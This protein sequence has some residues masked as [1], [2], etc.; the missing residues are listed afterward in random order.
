MMEACAISVRWP[1]PPSL[2]LVYP[3]ILFLTLFE[4]SLQAAKDGLRTETFPSQPGDTLIVRNDYGRVRVRTWDKKV[5][6][7]QIR[8]IAADD[9]HLNNVIVVSQ[10]SAHRIYLH[11]Y[12]YDYEAESVYI[13]L[14]VP[15]Y[16]NVFISGANPAVELY[17]LGG[18]ARVNTLTGLITAQDLHSSASLLTDTGDISYR[19]HTQPT[20]D[21]RLEAMRGNIHCQLT[22]KLNL[23]GWTRAGG[24]LS[25]NQ[26]IELKQGFLEKQM[27][28]GGPL[29]YASSLHGDVSIRL[30]P[31]GK[32]RAAPERAFTPS[33]VS[34]SR[35]QLLSSQ[36]EAPPAGKTPFNANPTPAWESRKE[37][38]RRE[39]HPSA[40]AVDPG[41]HLRVN[42]DWIYLNVSVRDRYSN[43]S[44]PG[45][46]KDDFLVYEDGVPQNV[47]KF[48]PTEA[49]FNLL[50]LL[51]V[52]GSTRNFLNLIKEASIEFTRQIKPNDRI[53]VAAFN[54]HVW[55]IQTFSNDRRTVGQAISRIRSGGGTAFYDAL[56]TC[57][58]DYMDGIEGRKAIVVFTDGVDNQ[59][60]GDYSHGSVITFPALYR[61]IQEIDS[62]IY[63]IFVNSEK[64]VRQIGPRGTGPTTMGG[65]LKD[66][67]RG[68]TP[69]YYPSQRGRYN[70]A[71][72]EEA[73]GQLQRIADQTGGRMYSPQSIRDLSHVYKE[74]ADDLR[75][76]YT[77][78]Y[79]S[80][81]STR[82]GDWREIKVTLRGRRN[83]VA[84]TRK[85]YYAGRPDRTS[86]PTSREARPSRS[87]ASL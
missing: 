60:T 51:D 85:G 86:L 31:K 27:G 45:L 58:R 2:L 64:Q 57:I 70:R 59:L 55:L 20:G 28:V 82:D 5:V 63:T 43:R 83:L 40:G 12:F 69:P 14:Q 1:Q 37:E 4:F 7:A 30:E 6:S 9:S 44:I 66:I 34:P 18:H 65:I 13:D 68:R 72:Y 48:D 38:A 56:E 46:Q 24:R 81:H 16:M 17:D 10:T 26:G 74:I 47:E 8:K 19:S 80:T 62:I 50:L 3:F 21:I 75:V 78:G 53:A 22:G 15:Q 35:T 71:A 79:N 73:Q 76:Q 41:Y 54:S 87:R 49:P 52:S 42:V 11:A 36:P 61:E 32:N 29:L 67:I 23:R 25:W 39:N 77:L 84:R 33:A